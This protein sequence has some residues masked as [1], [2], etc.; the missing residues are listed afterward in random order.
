MFDIQTS[1]YNLLLPHSDVAIQ[2]TF[3]FNLLKVSLF[4]HAKV[5]RKPHCL[6]ECLLSLG[7]CSPLP[8]S[9]CSFERDRCVLSPLVSPKMSAIFKA[10]ILLDLTGLSRANCN[11]LSTWNCT[12][13]VSLIDPMCVLH[14][15]CTVF[16][17]LY[18]FC[19]LQIFWIEILCT[20][21]L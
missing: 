16:R 2:G 13:L 3:P 19:V 4:E 8:F 20:K 21:C 18:S 12:G 5:L 1:I 9:T 6:G 11:R 14:V 15:L 17:S 10:N 7:Y